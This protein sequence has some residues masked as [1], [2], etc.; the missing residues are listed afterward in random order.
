VKA[1]HRTIGSALPPQ[2][3]SRSYAGIP[4]RIHFDDL[5]LASNA[6][7]DLAHYLEG[8]RTALANIEASFTAVGQSLAAAD[9]VLDLPCGYGRLLRFLVQHV[10]SRRIWVADTDMQAVRFCVAE[11]GVCGFTAP[12]DPT[13]LRLP[14]AFD[15]VYVGSL[16]THLPPESGMVLL[17][18]ITAGLRPG[19]LLVFSTQ[20]VSCPAHLDW[21]GPEFAAA[22]EQY[23]AAVATTGAGFWPYRAK[24]LA[25]AQSPADGSYRIAILNRTLVE[26]MILRS[27][28]A[29]RVARFV[30]R[31]LHDHQDIWTLVRN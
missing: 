14:R 31:G 29:M 6:P 1:L 12:R 10:P 19:G 11:F 21:Y 15:L 5:M 27:L 8:G 25:A 16:L 30:E 22:A 23:R 7:A 28:P 9:A 3:F 26:G 17:E 20:G 13:A 4:G 2:L 24:R 18:R